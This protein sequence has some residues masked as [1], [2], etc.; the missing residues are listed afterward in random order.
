MKKI[1]EKL[2][3][4]P[5]IPAGLAPVQSMGIRHL[6]PR[7]FVA[8][9]VSLPLLSG[10]AWLL[11]PARSN[12]IQNLG[13]SWVF[14]ENQRGPVIGDLGGVPV[15]IPKPYAHLVEYEGDP[16]FMERRKEPA[17][18]R[19]FASRL[20]SFGFEV[21]YP[22]MAAL[23][24]ET[25]PQRKSE[26]IHNT[27]WLD[28]GIGYKALYAPN[29]D[30]SLDRWINYALAPDNFPY[31]Y[32]KLPDTLHGLVGYTPIGVTDEMR[33]SEKGTGWNDRNIY[34]HLKPDGKADAYIECSNK[35]HAAAPC[36][37]KFN[38]LPQMSIDVSVGLRRGLLPHWKEIQSSVTQV[39]LGFRVDP[40]L[41]AAQPQ[42]R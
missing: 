26:N 27:T 3:M 18:K 35:L 40:L 19:T 2:G 21:R 8:L 15:L 7:L 24:A 25:E 20:S 6:G 30:T 31:R 1:L 12:T 13:D 4:K 22:D 32:E 14:R 16:H 9:L 10:L 29:G 39:I 11:L 36:Q 33:R 41:L 23:T 5:R 28:V 37:L 42:E 17:P 38:L 34:Y